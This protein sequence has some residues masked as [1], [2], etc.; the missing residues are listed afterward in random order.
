MSGEVE[1]DLFCEVG[2]ERSPDVEVTASNKHDADKAG[3]EEEIS[4]AESHVE[5]M[6]AGEISEREEAEGLDRIR[7][8]GKIEGT[9]GRDSA[10]LEGDMA[11]RLFDLRNTIRD[12]VAGCTAEQAVRD[13]GSVSRLPRQPQQ[14]VNVQRREIERVSYT[15]FRFQAHFID[16]LFFEH[17]LVTH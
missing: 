17:N 12:K 15:K 7:E 10:H 13:G 1:Q 9:A 14:G 11:E 8:E 16:A 3:G 5:V 6:S 2:S 4:P